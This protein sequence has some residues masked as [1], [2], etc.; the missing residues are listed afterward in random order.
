GI[1]T[2]P[3]ALGAHDAYS[4][5]PLAYAI[6]LVLGLS[7][8]GIGLAKSRRSGSKNG[9]LL[10][11]WG[12]LGMAVGLFDF[13]LQINVL[14]PELIYLGPYT[15]LGAFL[16]FMHIVHHRYLEA[17]DAVRR[18]NASLQQQLAAREQQ[19][20][21]SYRRLRIIE[22]RQTRSEER[23]RLMQDMH[24]GM[25]SSLVSALMAVESGP[26]DK[27]AVTDILRACIDDLR[28]TIDSMEPIQEDLLLLLATLRFRLGQRLEQAGVR[29]RWQVG[30]VPPLQ[31]LD[32]RSSLHVLRILQ[33]AFTNIVKHAR[34]SEIEVG[35]AVEDGHVLVSIRDNGI[36]F[37]PEPD[38]AG[39][40]KGVQNQL[41]R[42]AAIGAQLNWSV[43][44]GTLLVMRLPIQRSGAAPSA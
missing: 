38:G 31:W 26:L 40:G 36:G 10:S 2:L 17:H 5:A 22:E 18:A 9:V 24:D 6:L 20:D 12:I 13:L 44:G 1:A 42:A 3:G 28:L 16:V 35:T 7:L 30:A 34:A 21:A 19:L 25:G 29:L 33:E 37:A 23:Q 8:A 32:P 39:H 4:I 27:A 14:D 41:R 11:V 15:N 43:E